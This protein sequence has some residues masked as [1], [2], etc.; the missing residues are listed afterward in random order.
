VREIRW[1]NQAL[2]ALTSLTTREQRLLLDRLEV[3]GQFPAM[4]PARQRGRF[5]RLRYFVINKRWLV[6]YRVD[7]RGI[8]RIIAIVPA[9]ARP[10]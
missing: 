3:A 6:Y 9:L 8:L 10:R 7:E 2:L 1:T 5:A 4:Y